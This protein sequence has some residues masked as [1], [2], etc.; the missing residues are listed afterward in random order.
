MPIAP[1][2]LLGALNKAEWDQPAARRRALRDLHRLHRYGLSLRSP[3]VLTLE[4]CIDFRL[5]D[6]E[7]LRWY[8]GHPFFSGIA[9]LVERQIVLEHY[10]PD[11]GP[12]QVHSLQSI[13]QTSA[14]LI[15][16]HLIESG[17][18]DPA[19][20]ITAY[21]PEAGPAYARTTAQ[22]ALDMAVVNDYSEDVYDP[23]ATVGRLGCPRVAARRNRL[24]RRHPNVSDADRRLD[25]AFIRRLA[26]MGEQLAD[27][28][29]RP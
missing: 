17:A 22:D 21:L 25:W 13:T 12:D 26:A 4:A 5:H 3:Q 11:F 27:F 28:L 29:T 6:L 15:A 14:H 19:E 16:G 2:I 8:I 20:F 7:S 24:A 1:G 18:F 9:V 23:S 10:P